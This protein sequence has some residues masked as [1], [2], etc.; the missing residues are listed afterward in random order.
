VLIS[1]DPGINGCGVAYFIDKHL[2]MA[3]YVKNPAA[4]HSDPGFRAFSMARA[5]LSGDTYTEG[6]ELVLEYPQIYR[7]PRA[8]NPN[9]LLTLALVDGALMGLFRQEAI[10]YLPHAWK[11]SVDP[12]ECVKRVQAR[13]SAVET[14]CVVLPAKSLAHNLWDAVGI[15]LFH[16]G[17]FNPRRVYER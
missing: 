6:D 8:N 14:A 4:K 15:G 12:D 13:L 11:G 17:R 5:V 16:L 2:V 1:I 9:N 10:L 3:Q 7:G